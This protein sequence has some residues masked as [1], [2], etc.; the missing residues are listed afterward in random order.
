[1]KKIMKKIYVKPQM[2]VVE[3]KHSVS[4]LAG[5]PGAQ[6]ELGKSGVQFA[7]GFDDDDFDE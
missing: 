5:S 6:D 7:P 3:I 4:L 2:E 1:M